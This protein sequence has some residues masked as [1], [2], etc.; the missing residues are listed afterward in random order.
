MALQED[1]KGLAAGQL[2]LMLLIIAGLMLML[3]LLTGF[4]SKAE[5]QE[6][7]ILCYNS[8]ATRAFT[9]FG[10]NDNIKPFP[11]LCKTIDRDV[12]GNREEIQA[13]VSHMMSRCW[14]MF[15]Q[16]KHEEILSDGGDFF[17]KVLNIRPDGNQCFLCYTASIENKEIEDGP[18]TPKDLTR[19]MEET[20][21]PTVKGVTYH[22]YI[23]KNK[24]PGG[25][26]IFDSI[27]PRE[28]YGI[29]FLSRNKKDGGGWWAGITGTIATAG[30]VLCY[31]AEPCGVIATIGL[32]VIGGSGL[33][34]GGAKAK[35]E[36][37][38]SDERDKS[39]VVFDKLSELEKQKCIVGD[40]AG[41]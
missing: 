6:E 30:T 1:R 3:A 33:I 27:K 40:L 11:V 37:F 13:Q 25:I 8:I 2:V 24:G 7:E 5:G 35:R 10:S 23:V 38:N 19:Y 29:V 41:G 14:W 15:G 28:A 34:A 31:V 17:S 12:V 9:T 4:F 36:F 21:H 18:I 22:D 39:I 26:A 16:G 32:G 20:L